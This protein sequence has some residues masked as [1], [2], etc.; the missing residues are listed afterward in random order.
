M[1][2]QE[3]TCYALQGPCKFPVLFYTEENVYQVLKGGTSLTGDNFKDASVS[4]ILRTG[5]S[6]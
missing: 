3:L 4:A 1:L 5:W 2:H 6:M